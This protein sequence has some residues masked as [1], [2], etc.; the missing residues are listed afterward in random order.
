MYRNDGGKF[1]SVTD[2]AGVTNYN[3][4]LSVNPIDY[5]Q[6]GDIDLHIAS[7]YAEP[8][9]LYT[10][11]GNGTFVNRANEAFRHIVI[12]QWELMLPM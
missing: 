9:Y 5:D 6:D 12:L 8:D 1:T 2:Q 11:D 4:T 3:Y 10:N 7:D